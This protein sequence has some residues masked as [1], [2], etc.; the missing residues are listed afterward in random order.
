LTEPL[1]AA[2]GAEAE[3][4]VGGAGAGAVEANS[5]APCSGVVAAE[6]LLPPLKREMK[7]RE[8][9]PARVRFR[10]S[11]REKEEEGKEES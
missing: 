7:E 2:S 8:V 9:A 1:G 5:V 4:A 3:E 6:A 11:A 10:R